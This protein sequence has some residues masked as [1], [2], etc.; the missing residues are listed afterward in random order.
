MN[1]KLLSGATATNGAPTAG[2]ETVGFPL[3]GLAG[4]GRNHFVP[5]SGSA[6]L[7]LKSTAGSGTMTGT[8]RLWVYSTTIDDWMP[9]GSHTTLASRGLLNEAVAITEDPGSDQIVH[10]ELVNGLQHFNRVYLQ[11]TAIGGTA[12]AFD[13][14]L[15]GR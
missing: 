11:I 15:V 4:T 10:A 7:I 2:D 6:A 14:Y 9:Y 12:T 13:A 1:I 8:F 3:Q 5:V